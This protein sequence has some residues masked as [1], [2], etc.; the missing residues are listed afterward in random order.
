MTS[1]QLIYWCI[2]LHISESGNCFTSRFTILFSSSH[3]Q[4]NSYYKAN[5]QESHCAF[6]LAN[7]ITRKHF[8]FIYSAQILK[9]KYIQMKWNKPLYYCKM[10]TFQSSFISTHLPKVFGLLFDIKIKLSFFLSFFRPAERPIE[11]N[12]SKY[13]FIPS[14][15][16]IVLNQNPWYLKCSHNTAPRIRR[17]THRVQNMPPTATPFA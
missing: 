16:F 15:K 7:N 12:V 6:K 5:K 11:K 17:M 13:P 9:K 1:I 4:F 14:H 10:L 3:F 8:L 2:L